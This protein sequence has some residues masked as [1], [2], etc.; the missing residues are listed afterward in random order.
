[1]AA[2][3]D[4]GL[5]PAGLGCRDTL[6]FEACLPLYGHELSPAISPLEAGLGRFVNLEKG[7]FT[8]REALAEQ[9]RQGVKRK[10]CGFALVDR[11]VA[12]AEYPVLADG[13]QVGVVTSGTFAPT[14][15]K[16]LGL[17]LVEAQYAAVGQPLA[18][19]IRGKNVA[20]EV[21]ARPFYKREGK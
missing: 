18:I 21:I 8:G 13:R 17:A 4:D 5:Q 15:E 11:G 14:L 19:E 20:A 2:G 3:K 6:R 1:M 16:N 12:R 7:E 10:I 9:K